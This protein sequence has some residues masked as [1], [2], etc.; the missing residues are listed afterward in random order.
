MLENLNL[1]SPT[2]F[3]QSPKERST[4]IQICSTVTPL[5]HNGVNTKVE[6]LEDQILVIKHVKTRINLHI[7]TEKETLRHN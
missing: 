3:I 2:L 6:R 1:L 7:Q 4:E 5:E